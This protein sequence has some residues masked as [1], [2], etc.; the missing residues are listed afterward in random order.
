MPELFADPIRLPGSEETITFRRITAG[1]FRRGARG[2]FSDEEPIHRVV[3]AEDFYLGEFPVT[4]AQFAAWTETEDYAAWFRE[5]AEIIR[6]TSPGKVAEPHANHFPDKPNHPAEN[7]TWWE[8]RSFAEWLNRSRAL[9]PGWRADLPSEAQW[10]HACRSGTETAYWSGDDEADLA[11]V[12]WYGG[13]AGGETHPVGA[14]G[15][16]G[17]NPWGLSD[18]HGNVWEWCLDYFDARRYRKAVEG[19]AGPALLEKTAVE[20][21]GA[22]PNHVAWAELMTRYAGEAPEVT[23]ADREP[24]KRLLGMA[25]RIVKNGDSSWDEVREGSDAALTNGTWPAAL[26]GTARELRD[27]FRGWV[28]SATSVDSPARVLRGGAWYD[29]ASGCRAAY[30]GR[31]APGARGWDLRLPLGGGPRVRRNQPSRSGAPGRRRER[32]AERGSQAEVRARSGSQSAAKRR[33][34]FFGKIDCHEDSAHRR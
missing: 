20:P 34:N 23:E 32:R 16:A 11:R 6:E 8:A 5:N 15:P 10:E 33:R 28:D 30:R 27:I 7:V 9:P 17:A 12:G 29:S 2:K 25:E 14:F 24:L 21:E 31:L 18:L 4:Q 3:I 13:N 26:Q 1:T 22:N 19:G